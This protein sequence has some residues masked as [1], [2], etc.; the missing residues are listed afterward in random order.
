METWSDEHEANPWRRVQSGAM[1]LGAVIVAGSVA[2]TVIGLTPFDA[3]YQTVL[4]VSTVGYREIGGPGV[5]VESAAYKLVTLLVI[6]LGVGAAFFTLGGAIEALVE[7]RIN[8]TRGRHRMQRDID[9]LQGHVV[10]CGWGQVGQA[11]CREVAG[12]DSEVVVV[13]RRHDLAD[14]VPGYWVMG[15]AT[16]DD[17]L[18]CAGIERA[19]ALVVALDTDADNVYVTLSGRALNPALVIVARANS[20]LAE[21]KLSRAGANHVVNPH[22]IGGSRMAVLALNSAVAEYVSKVLHDDHYE[23]RLGEVPVHRRLV[24]QSLEHSGVSTGA[25]IVVLAIARNGSFV[26]NPGRDEVLQE[27]D[28]LVTL[29]TNDQ[30]ALARR[31]A[32]GTVS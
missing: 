11:I 15:E 21:E 20:E 29:G 23:V 18:R 2:Y 6:L 4:T 28:V 30:Q 22:L 12:L 25:E 9:Q 10:V 32:E 17:V 13:D 5:D 3:L 26:H 7:M 16:D 24:G 19:A 8:G 14:V 31:L 1:L 27:G